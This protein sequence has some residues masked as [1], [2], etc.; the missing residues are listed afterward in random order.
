MKTKYF[1]LIA[2]AAMMATPAM[3]NIASQQYVDAQVTDLQSEVGKKLQNTFTEKNLAM[4]TDGDGAVKVTTVK[5]GMIEASNV[6]NAKLAG[7]IGIDKLELP[8]KC[9][10]GK[11]CILVYNGTEQKYTWEEIGRGTDTAPTGGISGSGSSN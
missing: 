9:T 11:T 8:T 1:G 3:A 2:G 4:T 5:T 10:S 7:G 6:T